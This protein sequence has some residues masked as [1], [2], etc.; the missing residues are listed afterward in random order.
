M[1]RLFRVL[2]LKGSKGSGK[3]VAGVFEAET[4]DI[5]FRISSPVRGNGELEKSVPISGNK[6]AVFMPMVMV[7]SG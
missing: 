3:A 1:A 5:C 2:P 6:K 4:R 7:S